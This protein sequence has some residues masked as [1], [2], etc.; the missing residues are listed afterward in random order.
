[1]IRACCWSASRCATASC[2]SSRTAAAAPSSCSRAHAQRAATAF[3]LSTPCP[4]MRSRWRSMLE[5]SVAASALALGQAARRAHTA[6]KKAPA[7]R[8]ATSMACALTSAT[9]RSASDAAMTAARCHELARWAASP[10]SNRSCATSCSRRPQLRHSGAAAVA[11]VVCAA[12]QCQCGPVAVRHMRQ[13]PRGESAAVILG[14]P[15]GEASCACGCAQGHPRRTCASVFYKALPHR[16][17][18]V[19]A[20]RRGRLWRRAAL[21]R[22]RDT[23]KCGRSPPR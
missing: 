18:G 9:H 20:I 11:S 10:A 1:M 15:S 22:L 16:N 12:M 19:A 17:S 5:S 14:K 3:A 6:S 2:C 13:W 23:R 7:G 4:G 8:F 21:G